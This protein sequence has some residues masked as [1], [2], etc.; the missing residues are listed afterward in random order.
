MAEA[1]AN[2]QLI[3]RGDLVLFYFA[4]KGRVAH[5]GIVMRS[6]SS[7]VVTVEANTS[8]GPGVDRDGDGIYRRT[9]SWSELGSRGGFVRVPW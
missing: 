2:P 8:P 5:I 3:Q 7:G 9:R 6:H 1:R 4:A